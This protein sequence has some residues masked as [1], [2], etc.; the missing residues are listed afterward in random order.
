MYI[1]NK[2]KLFGMNIYKLCDVTEYIFK[3]TGKM[4]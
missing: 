1:H 2:L 4:Q 3:M